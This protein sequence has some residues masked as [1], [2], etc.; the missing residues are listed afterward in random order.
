MRTACLETGISS[1]PE[2]GTFCLYLKPGFRPMQRTQCKNIACFLMQVTQQAT[3]ALNTWKFTTHARIARNSNA[4]IE[5]VS[6]FALRALRRLRPLYTFHA[7]H[8]F[9][10][11]E[12]YVNTARLHLI[13]NTMQNRAL[14]S[15]VWDY[16]TTVRLRFLERRMFPY[17]RGSQ[18]PRFSH[19][20]S[21]GAVADGGAAAA[22]DAAT[23]R[24][25]GG[26]W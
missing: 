1:V 9:R 17:A 25:S 20:C 4:S 13:K 7:L 8:A 3:N 2:Y 18:F 14:V 16:G 19:P 6:M 22:A 24:C 5:A 15:V 26:W 23:E 12:K 10:W 21:D 11:M